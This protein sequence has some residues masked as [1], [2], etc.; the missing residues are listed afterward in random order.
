MKKILVPTDFS[1]NAD[2][3]RDYAINLAEILGAEVYLLNCY[4][5]PTTGLDGGGVLNVDNLVKDEAEKQMQNQLEYVRSN[6]SNLKFDGKCT[7]GL[8]VD[9]VK[10]L[11]KDANFNLIVLGTN[12]TSG[13]V[14][15]ILGSN[16]SALIGS[17][18]IPVITVPAYTT[19]NFPKRIIVANDLT[20][21]GE[22]HLYDSLK[23]IAGNT[24]ASID[25]LFIVDDEKKAQ[26]KIQRLKAANFDEAFDANY[27]PFHFK[28]SDNAEDGI[29]EY[30]EGKNYDLLVVVCHQR[31]FW[32]RIFER[33]I[34][35]SLVKHAEIPILVLKD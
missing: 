9:S 19:I 30:L 2:K 15:N 13:V 32:E 28:N 5:L 24:N 7:P 18:D 33:S 23:E 35:K 12:G 4:H 14:E 25:F 34:S 17:I 16:A 11:A 8:M 6:H 20:E 3:A 22:N 1:D 21:S 26:N 10:R 29:L 27:H 31:S